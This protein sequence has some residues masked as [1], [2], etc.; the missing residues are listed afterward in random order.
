[1]EK[2]G[3]SLGGKFHEFHSRKQGLEASGVHSLQAGEP[4]ALGENSRSKESLSPDI[5]KLNAASG[6]RNLGLQ[7]NAIERF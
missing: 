1:M 5:H 3:N 6:A 7:K 4:S 2:R